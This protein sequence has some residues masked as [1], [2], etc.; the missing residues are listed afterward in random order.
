MR[1]YARSTQHLTICPDTA[2]TPVNTVKLIRTPHFLVFLPVVTTGSVASSRVKVLR[3]A[4]TCIPRPRLLCA[5]RVG[6]K[7]SI[8]LAVSEAFYLT[9]FPRSFC[10]VWGE[11]PAGDDAMQ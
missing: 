6:R 1:T 7:F 5:G 4:L 9:A 10:A 3:S 2:S 11:G 8:Y